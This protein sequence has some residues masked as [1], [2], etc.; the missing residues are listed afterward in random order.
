MK[1]PETPQF[2]KIIAIAVVSADGYITKH[3]LPGVGFA[4]EADQT[5]FKT[6]LQA[7][8]CSVMGAKTFAVSQAQILHGLRPN[9]L[10][11]VITRHPLQYAHYAQPGILEFHATNPRETIQYLTQQGKQHCA[12]LGGSQIYTEY[13]R[14][15]LIDE[16]WLTIEPRLFGRGKKL[17]E[18]D[19]DLEFQIAE[20]RN[21]SEH[22]LLIKYRKSPE[23]K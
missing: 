17:I 13:F 14:A 8:D 15:G 2:M 23:L 11:I 19:L 10:R 6:S 20:V 22:V 9:R 1:I 5:F 3:E 4:S 12:V 7:F 18:G 16:L 21:L